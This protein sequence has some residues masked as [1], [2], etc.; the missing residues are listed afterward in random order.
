MYPDHASIPLENLPWDKYVIVT[1]K[2]AV[3]MTRPSSNVLALRIDL[4]DWQQT[5]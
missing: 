1:E 4:K 2:D 3:R 5:Q